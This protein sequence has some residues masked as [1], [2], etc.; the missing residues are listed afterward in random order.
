MPQLP[1]ELTTERL[2]LRRYF[3]D[4]ADWYAD[5]A[6]RNRAHLARYESGNAAMRIASAADAQKVIAEFADLAEAEKACFL[7]A[8]LADSDTFV[9]QI[10]VGVG[11]AALPAYLIGYFCDVAHLRRGY[12]GEAAAAVV[13]ELFE[14]CGAE[15]VGLGC[16]DTNSASRRIAE[17]LGMRL[18]GHLRADKRNADGSVTGSLLFG[19]LRQEWRRAEAI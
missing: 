9:A 8:F 5:M 3:P 11:N 1:R 19:L 13:A 17:R 18:E 6:Q 14:R 12:V 15:R 16:D 4:D 2:R 7:G 10:Y